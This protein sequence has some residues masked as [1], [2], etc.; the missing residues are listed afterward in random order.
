[1]AIQFLP[2]NSYPTNNE[3]GFPIGQEIILVFNKSVDL[4]SFKE[5]FVLYGKDGDRTSG[6]DNALWVNPSSVESPFFLTSPEF[7]GF[8]E[9][10]FKISLVDSTDSLVIEQNQY[11]LS[12]S[13]NRPIVVIAT[14]KKVLKENNSY[15]YFLSGQTIENFE[16]LPPS[17]LAIAEN[18]SVSERTVYDA[19]KT[20]S[21]VE[22]YDSRIK[23]WLIRLMF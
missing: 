8:L 22:T 23:S 20:I 15:D 4:K 18:K 14:P 7:K 10:D 2:A 21:S 9:C 1:M 3:D 12:K 17:L 13:E 6:P 16:N 11:E 19:F 5:A